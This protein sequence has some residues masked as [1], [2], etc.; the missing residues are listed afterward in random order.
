MAA[1][2]EPVV[3]IILPVRDGAATLGTAV[4]SIRRQSFADWELL[5]LDDGSADASAAVAQD[6][7]D[8]RIRVLVDGQKRGLATRLNQGIDLARGRYIARMDADDVAYPERL[9]KQVEFLDRNADVDLLGTR[10][11]LYRAGGE[12]VGEFPFRATHA[13]ICARPWNGFYLP[14]PTWMGRAEWFRRIRYRLPEVVWAEDQDLLLR[15]YA[16]SCFACLPDV[17]L[18]YCVGP[19]RLAKMLG[20]RVNLAGAQFSVNL[21]AGRPRHALLGATAF[22]AKGVVD[23]ARYLMGGSGAW[24]YRKA[25]IPAADEARWRSVWRDLADS[26]Q[27]RPGF[28]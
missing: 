24:R 23:A 22:L 1:S 20:V 19:T 17:L 9:A 27:A 5:V 14:H 13:E 26:R 15:A 16:S 10:V 25:G 8:P 3:S 28:E 6:S 7:G 11:L 18:G 21:R 4:D 12:P 2:E